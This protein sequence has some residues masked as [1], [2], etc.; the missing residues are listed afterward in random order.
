MGV[1]GSFNALNYERK[2]HIMKIGLH[3]SAFTENWNENVLPY[4]SLAKEIG[5]D[6]VEIPLM[7]PFNIDV[8]D[9]K[10]G[11]RTNNIEGTFGTGLNPSIDITSMDESVRR[12]GINHLKKCIDICHELG[13]KTLNGV[14]HSPWGLQTP[15][16]G[17]ETQRNYGIEALKEV[18]NYC[19]E[20]NISLCM[21]LL[22]RYESSYLNT[23]E[24]GVEMIEKIGSTHV[25]LH[26]DTFHANIEEKDLYGSIEKN[27][28]HIGHVHFAD[29]HRGTPGTGL[30]DFKRIVEVL[31]KSNYKNCIVVEC[32][33]IPNTEAG[34]DVS[35]WKKIET[36]PKKMAEDSYKYISGLLKEK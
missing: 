8:Q 31:E 16:G 21:E 36:S 20:K 25:L 34:N 22:N 17:Y 6:C 7:D 1:G 33:V 23:I 24:E 30:I 29:N 32:F 2:G 4:I 27:V 14:V 18:A 15:R 5:F 28:K 3:L 13:S 10:N 35:V 9:I 26:V 11:L 12:K 19:E